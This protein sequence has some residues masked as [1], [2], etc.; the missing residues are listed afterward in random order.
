MTVTKVKVP[1]RERAYDILVGEGLL[2]HAAEHI[3]PLLR[4][5]RVIVVADSAV[6]D[7]AETLVAGLKA[8]A[9]RADVVTL[10][11]GE[12]TKSFAQLETLMNA[13]LA[14]KPDRKTTLIAL[15]GGVI[16][17][18]VGF[19]ASI[20]LRGVD[21][22]QVPTTLLAQV[23]SSVGGKTGINTKAGKNLVGSFYQPK[24]V[25]VDV[26][27]LATLPP[28]EMRAGH[29]EILKYGLIMN[30]DFFAW[31]ERHGEEMLA[32][33]VAY[34]ARA[35]A[36]CCEMKAQIVGADEQESAERALLN[37]GHTFGHALEAECNYDGTLLHG[38]AVAIGMVMA[39][40]LSA[41]LGLNVDGLEE[42]LSAH[43]KLSGMPCSPKDIRKD[44]D[45]ARI[46]SHFASDKKAEAGT[47]TFIVLDALGKARVQKD[48]DAVLA[49][50]VVKE[51]IGG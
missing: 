5:P 27:T 32:G 10:A 35:I 49:S 30:A 38:E 9:I 36:A 17:D 48:V 8:R 11:G 44:W 46:V 29:A 40:R 45:V 2:T 33:N 24:A 37:F 23:D 31:C 26:T 4:A 25:L 18:L 22:I 15:G 39:L 19:A 7:F 28:R 20:L 6:K 16:G 41:K 21:F 43:L 50:E 47:L 12:Q 1:L 13:L 42:R 34:L 14:L 51:F 3:A